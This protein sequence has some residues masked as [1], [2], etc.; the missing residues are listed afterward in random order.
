MPTTC[1]RGSTSTILITIG[2]RSKC[3]Y[4]ESRGKSGDIV[5]NPDLDNV[6]MENFIVWFEEGR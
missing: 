1:I 6:E 5:V 3:I 4:S 2:S